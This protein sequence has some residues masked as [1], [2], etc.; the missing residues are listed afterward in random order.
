MD[1]PRAITTYTARVYDALQTI[2]YE[3]GSPFTSR[4]DPTHEIN[5]SQFGKS[6][7]VSDPSIHV[8]QWTE[9]YCTL[10][11]TKFR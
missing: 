3:A 9:A 2:A 11:T 1:L 4:A 8:L 6:I 7:N 5:W 10:C